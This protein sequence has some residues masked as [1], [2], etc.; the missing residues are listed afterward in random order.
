VTVHELDAVLVSGPDPTATHPL[1]LA[2][3]PAKAGDD[4]AVKRCVAFPTTVIASAAKQS[5]A[6]LGMD[7]FVGFASS[8]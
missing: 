1:L 7:C 3:N 5:M 4:G 6:P 2:V 8:Q